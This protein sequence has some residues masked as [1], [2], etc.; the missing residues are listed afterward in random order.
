MGQ[1][2]DLGRRKSLLGPCAV[3]AR[4]RYAVTAVTQ[5]KRH[6]IGH[7][8]FHTTARTALKAS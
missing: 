5:R 3:S 2:Y 1:P 8:N 6:E 7:I 4:T